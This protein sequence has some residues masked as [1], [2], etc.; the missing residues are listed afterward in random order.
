MSAQRLR[1]RQPTRLTAW[2]LL[3]MPAMAVACAGAFTGMA[4]AQSSTQ[5]DPNANQAPGKG[6]PPKAERKGPPPKA[7]GRG[8]P[9]NRE[10]QEGQPKRER[11][12]GQP[13]GERRG[14]PGGSEGRGP[15]Q[16][17]GERRGPPPRAGGD[18][19]QQPRIGRPP[20]PSGTSTQQQQPAA[21]TPPPPTTPPR[22]NATPRAG[23]GG[24]PSRQ[25]RI[26]RPPQQSGSSTQQQPAGTTPPSTQQQQQQQQRT[27]TPSAPSGTSTQQQPAGTT[28]STTQ[29]QRFGRSGPG[30]P[31]GAPAPRSIEDVRKNRETIRGS[32]GETFIRE[33]GNRTIIK[34]DNRTVIMRNEATSIQRFAPDARSTRRGNGITETVYAGRDG[35]RVF[36]ETDARGRIV[37]RYRRDPSGRETVMFDNRRFYRNLAIGIGVGAAIGI[38]AVAL[39]PPVVAMPRDKY[40]VNYVDASDEDIY[41][42]LTAPPIERLERAYSLDEVRYSEPLRARMRSVDLDNINFE[43]GSFDVTPDQYSKL[44]RVARA[45]GRAIERNPAEVFLIE[46]HTDAVGAAEDNLSLSD[47]RAEE[48]AHILYEQFRIPMENLVTQGYGEQYPRVQTDG[49]S[50]DNR[51]VGIR[52]I[53][54]FLS[55]GPPPRRR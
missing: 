39:A 49:P 32:K 50:R 31:S 29:P 48:V 27:G 41:D 33:P 43:T 25:P 15:P 19:G 26:G 10:R 14:P 42:A 9:P 6:P 23:G 35:G 46:G 8:P 12:E 21:N 5:T 52:R 36:T 38:A 37:R 16:P 2:R 1:G 28:P 40:I 24:D 3:M 47:R 45:L 20:A 18:P 17:G 44:E 51:R 11:Q 13:R 53:T 4:L 22:V 34:Q 55:E 7:E 30:G 54:P